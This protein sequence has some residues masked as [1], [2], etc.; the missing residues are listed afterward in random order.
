MLETGSQ[1]QGHPSRVDL[2]PFLVF[3]SPVP[4][5][6]HL[7]CLLSQDWVTFQK[8]KKKKRLIEHV[9]GALGARSSSQISWNLWAA[10]W[11]LKQNPGPLQVLLMIEPSL[12]PQAF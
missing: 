4:L 12:Q 3:S 8:K 7:F 11:M 1:E 9:P 6:S 10:V 2:A 5:I